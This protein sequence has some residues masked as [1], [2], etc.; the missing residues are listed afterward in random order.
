MATCYRCG[1]PISTSERVRRK[2]KTGEWMKRRFSSPKATSVTTRYGMRVVCS[3]C[4]KVLD[5]PWTRHELLQYVE[6]ALAV[7]FI[8]AVILVRLLSQ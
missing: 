6:L 8:A 4:A 2:V 3:E 7:G 1:R 5:A